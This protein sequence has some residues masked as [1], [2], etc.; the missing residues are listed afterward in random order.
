MA[1]SSYEMHTLPTL[2]QHPLVP[3]DGLA[4]GA[5]TSMSTVGTSTSPTL[6]GSYSLIKSMKNVLV[7][8]ASTENLDKA[9]ALLRS[10]YVFY[11]DSFSGPFPSGINL[12]L[13]H[14]S[15]MP[16]R[17]EGSTS[18][19]SGGSQAGCET[20]DIST[21]RKLLMWAFTL[22]H[23]RT[24]VVA[25]AVKYCEEQAKVSKLSQCIF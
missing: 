22:V 20:L 24:G 3:T 7:K 23:G 4:L 10:A 13:L 5:E 19:L 17:G 15:K 14:P 12:Y 8:Q 1:T 2:S 9:T 18:T 16:S 25:E 6:S 21:P 11:R